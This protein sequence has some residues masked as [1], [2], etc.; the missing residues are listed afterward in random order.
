MYEKH[1]LIC[2]D[3]RFVLVLIF[4]AVAL[5]PIFVK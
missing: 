5:I 2:R 1:G 3:G 4:I